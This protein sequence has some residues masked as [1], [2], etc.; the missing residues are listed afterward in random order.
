MRAYPWALFVEFAWVALFLVAAILAA[1]FELD[2]QARKDPAVAALV[3]Q[4]FRGYALETL[5]REAYRGGNYAAAASFARAL[6]ERR[7]VPAESLSLYADGLIATGDLDAALPAVELAAQRGWRDRST[8]RV[9]ILSAIQA[10]DWQVAAQR[11]LALWRQGERGPWLTDLTAT[12]LANPSALTAFTGGIIDHERYWGTDFLSWAGDIFPTDTLTAVAATLARRHAYFECDRISLRVGQ[13]VRTGKA[14]SAVALWGAA[15]AKRPV[16]GPRDFVF[17]LSDGKPGP[18]DW[19]LPEQAGLDVELREDGGATS[20]SYT[21]SEPIRAEI[22]K[23]YTVLGAG[24]HK[25]RLDMARGF[26]G[27]ERRPSLRLTCFSA[28]GAP[29]GFVNVDLTN[30]SGAIRIP[31]RDCASQEMTIMASRGSGEVRA[32]MVE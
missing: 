15:C 9:V 12:V 11:L 3:P 14:Q 17:R 25:T 4:P 31:A 7:P 30:S 26:G 5:A 20:L 2:R 19:R 10:G 16:I 13:M 29:Q 21:N 24:E 28:S 32:I 27:G 6:V 18:F 1:G 8:Q 22:A 23:R